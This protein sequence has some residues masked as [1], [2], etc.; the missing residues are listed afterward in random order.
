MSH[1]LNFKRQALVQWVRPY[2]Y[3]S[4]YL[5]V[6]DLK[7]RCQA[8]RRLRVSPVDKNGNECYEEW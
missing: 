3:L 8:T 2:L 4:S 1:K 6:R 5:I 7:P